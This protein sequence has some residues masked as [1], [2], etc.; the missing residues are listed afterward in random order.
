MAARLGE[1]NDPKAL[2]PG[3]AELI[4]GDLRQL[5]GTLRVVV[6]V[7]EELGR[8][9][10]GGWS[11]GAS[12]A[13]R[14]A[15]RAEPPRWLRA[16][17]DL[18]GG[19]QLLADYGDALVES[20]REAQRAVE[21]YLAA[22]AATRLAAAEHAA[23]A[24]SGAP[25]APFQ[26]PGQAGTAQA[27]KVLDDARK[28]LSG[29]GDVVAKALGWESDGEGGYKKSFGKET[30]GAAHRETDEEGEDTGG[31]QYGVDGRSYE[32]KSGSESKR[33]LTDAL[34]EIAEKIGI[35]LHERE[36]GDDGHV[37]VA[38]GEKDGDFDAGP[39]SGKGRI[40]GSVLGADAGYT[41]TASYAGVSVGAHA[42]AYLASG[43]ADGEV[44]LG[45]H[46]SVSGSAEGTIGVGGEVKGSIGVLGAKGDAE[47]FAGAKVSGE[48]GA[49]VAG[50][51][52]G[53]NG[54]AW[55]GIGGHASGQFGMGEDGKFHVGGSVGLAFGVG[56]KVGFDVSV[57]P[58]EVV[59]T[60]VDVADDVGEIAED[61]GRG[62]EHAGR[63]IGRLFGR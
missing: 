39:L 45:Q 8:I 15:L 60:V 12:G 59:E 50:I 61:V 3:E 49:E 7:G 9:D 14:S 5:V 51:G 25:T 19:G 57:D 41:A 27:Q 31:W 10:P 17:A 20:Q 40:G 47:A 35:D 2:V 37:D 42:G 55:A 52:A 26:D 36:W 13:F 48:A 4:S 21:L 53:V 38:H 28:G 24:L 54:E 46:A 33:L 62:V 18:G 29:I 43:Y 6:A 23:M 16:G 63:A 11:G 1:T 44:K 30:Y 58:V 32:S 56:G 22:R 34:G